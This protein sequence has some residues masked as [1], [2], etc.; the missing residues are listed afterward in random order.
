LTEQHRAPFHVIIAT[1]GGPE[2]PGVLRTQLA[3]GGRLVMP[4]DPEREREYQRLARVPRKANAAFDHE[5]LGGVRFV[6]LICAHG[7]PV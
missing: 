6:P 4:V 7:W 3:V 1:A 5:D 2:V